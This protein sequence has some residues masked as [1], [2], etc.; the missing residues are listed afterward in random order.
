MGKLKK[1]IELIAK[2]TKS[3]EAYARSKG[4]KIGK[5]CFISTREFDS[6]EGYLIEIG[7]DVR[8]SVGTSFYTHGGVSR[9][10]KIY[11]DPTLDYF[12][13]IKIGDH[14]NIGA[15]CMIMPGVTIGSRCI[16]GG[17]SV[18]TKSVPDGCMV[19]GNP[20]RFI[21]YTDDF[22]HRIKDNGLDTNTRGMSYH[23]KKKVLQT[24]PDEAFVKKP[25]IK[26]ANDA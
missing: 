8:L 25:N 10:R 20:A 22:Y 18:V 6:A 5:G 9:M 26:I 13:K 7:D 4:V 23:D 1:L 21:G 12:G 15:Y 11:N 24:L 17:G 19:A 2:Y 16:V 3:P 14:T